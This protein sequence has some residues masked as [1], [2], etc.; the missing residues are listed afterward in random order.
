MTTVQELKFKESS[1]ASSD[2]LKT[3]YISR[4]GTKCKSKIEGLEVGD[5]LVCVKDFVLTGSGSLEVVFSLFQNAKAS[6]PAVFQKGVPESVV[7]VKSKKR[8]RVS[9][10]KK[11]QELDGLQQEGKNNFGTVRSEYPFIVKWHKVLNRYV[12]KPIPLSQVIF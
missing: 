1:F 4:I 7:F 3:V 12:W 10:G 11:T 8:N 6:L 2:S 9:S 5:R